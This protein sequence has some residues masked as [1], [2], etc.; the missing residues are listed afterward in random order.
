MSRLGR[1]LPVI[2]PPVLAAG[3]DGAAG[4]IGG[5]HEAHFVPEAAHPRVLRS[6][7]YACENPSWCDQVWVLNAS[8]KAMV[9]SSSVAPIA[10]RSFA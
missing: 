6:H 7:N 5:L 9:A 3:D 1:S 8:R 2:H 10:A 4:V